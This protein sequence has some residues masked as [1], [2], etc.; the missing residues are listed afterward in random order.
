M[1]CFKDARHR[2]GVFVS[3]L[4]PVCCCVVASLLSGCAFIIPQA[5]ELRQR[6]PDGLATQVELTEVPFFPQKDFQCG[7]AALATSLAYFGAPVTADSLVDQV[8]LP[9]RRG[10][11]Q[12]ELLA[13][14]RRNGMV[15]YQIAPRLEDL[16]REVNA[17]FP[18]IILQDYGTFPIR[19]WHYAVAVG[20]DM[21]EGNL[22]FRSGEKR[23]LLI[24]FSIVDYTWQ[25]SEY[26]AIVTAPPERVPAT[27]KEAPYLKAV[28]ALEQ[29]GNRTAALT[30]YGAMLDRWPDSLGAGIGEANIRYAMGEL[31]KAEAILRKMVVRHPD[32]PEAYNNLAQ[33]LSDEGKNAEALPLAD[34]AVELGGR[35]LATALETRDAIA[36]KVAG[37]PPPDEKK[38]N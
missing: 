12:V 24:P 20:F 35:F 9:M 19:Y 28:L 36:L 4:V 5:E 21:T 11:L 18:V 32:A 14:A 13:S 25:E 1:T 15:A 8:Y 26:W 31:P 29:T 23:R 2:A 22:V 30:A 33:T 10:S 6:H 7:P 34:K 37:N 17:G 3:A 27:A 38:V 16:L